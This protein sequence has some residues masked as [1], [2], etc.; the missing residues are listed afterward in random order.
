MELLS[1]CERPKNDIKD[2]IKSHNVSAL[3]DCVDRSSLPED[4]KRA[5]LLDL[6]HQAQTGVVTS[7]H[8]KQ[9][10]NSR[11]SDELYGLFN[12]G[13]FPS[14]DFDGIQFEALSLPSYVGFT[15]DSPVVP[16]KITHATEGFMAAPV[17][18]LFPEN[19]LDGVQYAGDKIFYFID[20]FA[21][22]HINKTKLI[23]EN[24][25]NEGTLS[26]VKDLTPEEAEEY[27]VHWIRLH[28]YFHRVGSAP[29]PEYLDMKTFKPLAGLEESRVDM[30]AVRFIHEKSNLP[31]E[32]ATKICEFILAERLLRYAVEGIPNPNYDAIGSQVLANFLKKNG[33]L[34]ISN[35]KLSITD[36]YMEG[37]Y[38]FTDEVQEIEKYTEIE[39]KA[40]VKNRLIEFVN[41]NLNMAYSSRQYLHDDFFLMV[42]DSLIN[43]LNVQM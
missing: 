24:F 32:K 1:I 26:C 4:Y 29:V 37:V 28:E 9:V 43:G 42:R 5:M 2:D 17:V 25:V 27:S 6:E 11:K 34:K 10:I 8:C 38:K 40:Q 16:I 30:M 15:V 7:Q 12:A 13:Y 36:D 41:S 33:Y 22:R 21:A 3:M 18:A 20:K 35:D 19:H 31:R 23:L 39:N 14:L